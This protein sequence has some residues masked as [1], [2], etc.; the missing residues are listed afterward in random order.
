MD[1]VA[2]RDFRINPGKVWRRLLKSK[3]MIVT[4]TGRPIA[5]LTN[6][7]GSSLEDEIR[8]DALARG[9]AAVSKLRSHAQKLAIA[10]MK[11]KDIE[12]EILKSRKNR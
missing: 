2:V 11:R 9:A 1:S 12:K 4:S 3:R 6:I 8:V 10:G 7:R 5:L